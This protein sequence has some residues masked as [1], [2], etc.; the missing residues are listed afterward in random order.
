MTFN[1]VPL[2]PDKWDKKDKKKSNARTTNE[3]T[4]TTNGKASSSRT[5]FERHCLAREI[6]PTQ[7]KPLPHPHPRISRIS[8]MY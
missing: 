2:F 4:N 7:P 6:T 1:S 8:R 5:T 3:G